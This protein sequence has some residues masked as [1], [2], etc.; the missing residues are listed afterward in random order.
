MVTL[1]SSF[2]WQARYVSHVRSAKW[3]MAQHEAGH[4]EVAR[5]AAVSA[6]AI[7]MA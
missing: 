5:V 7:S 2:A 4:D 1:G 3:R 6:A